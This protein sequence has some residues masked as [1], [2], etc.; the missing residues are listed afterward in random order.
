LEDAS[1]ILS[2][3]V[4]RNG[5]QV[6]EFKN[7]VKTADFGIDS[8]SPIVVTAQDPAGNKLNQTID[9]SVYTAQ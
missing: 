8:L 9:L 1:G 3:K 5:V 6:Y 7:G 2:G 4:T